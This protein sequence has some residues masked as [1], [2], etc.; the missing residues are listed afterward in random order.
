M[1]CDMTTTF[2]RGGASTSI[3]TWT[4]VSSVSDAAKGSETSSGF[5]EEEVDDDLDGVWDDATGS[6]EIGL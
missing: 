2:R 6:L 5:K 3:S 4:A 1:D